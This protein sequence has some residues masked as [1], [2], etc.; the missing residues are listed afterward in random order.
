MSI[1]RTVV[2]APMALKICTQSSVVSTADSLGFS[3]GI[4]KSLTLN[5]WL[6]SWASSICFASNST[7]PI[8]EVNVSIGTRLSV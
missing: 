2:F 8:I 5:E 7:F 4:P 1:S 6:Y 3:S